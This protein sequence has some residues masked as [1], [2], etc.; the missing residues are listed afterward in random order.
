MTLR[1][2]LRKIMKMLLGLSGHRIELDGRRK[3]MKME[4]QIAL[5]HDNAL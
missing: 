5:L 4:E 2:E 3:A 1:W